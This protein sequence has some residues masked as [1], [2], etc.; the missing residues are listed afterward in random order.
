MNSKHYLP[1]NSYYSMYG[2]SKYCWRTVGLWTDEWWMSVGSA[3]LSESSCPFLLRTLQH[4]ESQRRAK[5]G[6]FPS[7]CPLLCLCLSLHSVSHSW[8]LFSP[9]APLLSPAPLDPLWFDWTILNIHACNICEL[10]TYISA[11]NGCMFWF[12]VVAKGFM[13]TFSI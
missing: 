11:D 6:L 1:D 7:V 3:V 12:V 13:V 2:V 10:W 5:C 4:I 9:T 8:H